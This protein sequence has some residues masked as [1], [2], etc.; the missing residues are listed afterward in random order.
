[1]GE[2]ATRQQ[3][4]AGDRTLGP[5]GEHRSLG[6]LGESQQLCAGGQQSLG[7]PGD[8]GDRLEAEFKLTTPSMSPVWA[9]ARQLEWDQSRAAGPGTCPPLCKREGAG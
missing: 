4:S 3:G 7:N 1:M 9:L 8:R 5:S 6:V 2:E